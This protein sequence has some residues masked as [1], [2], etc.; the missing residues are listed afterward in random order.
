VTKADNAGLG[1]VL[2]GLAIHGR[3]WRGGALLLLTWLLVLLAGTT[4]CH[5]IARRARQ[6]GIQPWS[7]S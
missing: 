5:L 2:L 1:L 7:R 6:L 4:G 3:S